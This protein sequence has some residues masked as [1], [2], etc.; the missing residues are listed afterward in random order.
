[1]NHLHFVQ[2]LE[3]LQG[4]GLGTAAL[5]LHQ[6]LDAKGQSSVA[7]TRAATFEEAWPDVTQAIR[8]GPGSIYYS[9]SLARTAKELVGKS[10]WIH[11]HG[12]YV[13]PNLVFGREARRQDKPYVS[14]IHGFFDPWILNRSRGKK[15]VVNALFESKNL[16][17]SRFLRA[18]TEKEERQIRA[19][20][21][22]NPITV[23]PNGIDLAEVDASVEPFGDAIHFIRKRPRRVFFL[24]GLHPKKGLD[25]LI[26]AW[27]KLAAEFPD[28]ELA[29]VGP[30]EGGYQATIEEL[31]ASTIWKE[32]APC[33]HRSSVP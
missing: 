20:G 9:H 21:L 30:D 8:K 7:S 22:K 17:N 19:V 25:L 26:P 15:R 12:L 23:I 4:G 2:S 28:W 27:A 32:V 11:G 31:I 13:Y 18:L 14:H 1:M 33:F 29:I 3:P 16:K 6:A 10:D 5:Q 24:K